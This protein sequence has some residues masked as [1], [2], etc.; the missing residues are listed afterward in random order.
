[1][2]SGTEHRELVPEKT[3][4]F[5]REGYTLL[6]EVS[7]QP[8]Q[9]KTLLCYKFVLLRDRKTQIIYLK[10]HL[11]TYFPVQANRFIS[12]PIPCPASP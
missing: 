7:N 3:I 10:L 9:F 5:L 12:H 11:I 6:P 4:T 1:M 8:T 2:G